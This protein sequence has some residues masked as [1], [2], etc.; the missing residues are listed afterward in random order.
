[1][2]EQDDAAISRRKLIKSLA[3]G[4]I[5]VAAL[6][7]LMKLPEVELPKAGNPR[8]QGP[9][10]LSLIDA[11]LVDTQSSTEPE[12]MVQTLAGTAS[13][14]VYA[15]LSRRNEAE[16]ADYVIFIDGSTIKAKNGSTGHIDYSGTFPTVLQNVVNAIEAS[17]IGAGL[18]F[19]K[20]GVY[21][22]G[23]TTIHIN[24]PL[25]IKGE[26]RGDN[27]WNSYYPVKITY[28][29]TGTAFQFNTAGD[30]VVASGLTLEHFSLM[31]LGTMESTVGIGLQ[32]A[33][34]CTLQD[35]HVDSFYKGIR[36]FCYVGTGANLNNCGQNN[37]IK[38]FV[39]GCNLG[40]ALEGF[41][42]DA[43][44][45]GTADT[46]TIN[47]G[48]IL[49]NS[50]SIGD[51]GVYMN[52]APATRILSLEAGYF[53]NSL[54]YNACIYFA[55]SQAFYIESPIFGDCLNGIRLGT[56][57][58]LSTGVI[59]NPV[60]DNNVTN[61]INDNGILYAPS[62]SQ[63]GPTSFGQ[64]VMLIGPKNVVAILSKAGTI[65]DSDFNAAPPDGTLGLDTADGRLYVRS[66]GVWHYLTLT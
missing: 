23:A 13:S 33:F 38:I 11:Q 19:L 1:M 12:I 47:G 39:K 66:A 37:L 49:G 18:I 45:F 44:N 40:V 29:G 48:V 35:I 55:N 4:G 65:S 15:D 16:A 59:I 26:G 27:T 50:P 5:G 25:T 10:Y 6:A 58:S 61:M 63:G 42:T 57:N 2:T 21:N 52:Y 24:H 30:Q 7:A 14:P 8:K 51:A 64:A 9:D 20:A 56:G 28:S 43:S 22:L 53:N 31:N 54:T 17:G 62:T 32:N 3:L 60:V 36:I 34:Q 41:H 46:T